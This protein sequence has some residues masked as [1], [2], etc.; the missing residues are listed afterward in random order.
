MTDHA[1]IPGGVVH[2]LPGDLRTALERDSAALATWRDITPLARNEWICWIESAKK[3]ETRSKRVDW[4]RESLGEGKR[5]PC[6][7][8]GCPHR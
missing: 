4:G 3:E 6:C 1:S 2:E 5:R 7:W 8:P